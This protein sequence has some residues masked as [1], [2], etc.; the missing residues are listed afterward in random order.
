[1][2]WHL[3][4]IL[5]RSI[6]TSK[7]LFFPCYLHSCKKSNSDKSENSKTMKSKIQNVLKQYKYSIIFSE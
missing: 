7:Q 2:I 3:P 4:P 6:K 5:T 1:M